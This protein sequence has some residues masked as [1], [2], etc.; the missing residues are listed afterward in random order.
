[1]CTPGQPEDSMIWVCNLAFSDI[2][3]NGKE[4]LRILGFKY[5]RIWQE[6]LNFGPAECKL[7]KCGVLKNVIQRTS[8]NSDIL[9]RGGIRGLPRQ[10][11]KGIGVDYR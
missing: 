7:I 8:I 11:C 5:P 3:D 2:G 6:T 4:P 10:H 9:T 1:M